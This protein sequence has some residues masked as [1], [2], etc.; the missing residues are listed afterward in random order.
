MPDGLQTDPEDLTRSNDEIVKEIEVENEKDYLKELK[1]KNKGFL[2]E[3]DMLERERIA[4]WICDRHEEALPKHKELCDKLDKYDEVYRMVPHIPEG[5][6]GDD[7]TYVSPLSTVTTEVIHANVMNVIHSPKEVLRVLPTEEGDVKKVNKVSVF[8]NWSMDNE[9]DLFRCTDRLF[10]SSAKNGECP[11][12]MTCD[13]QYGTEIIREIL[14]NPANPTEPL[15]DPNTKEVLYQEVEKTKLLY[16]GPKF[17]VFSR[18]DYIQ[19]P[20]AMMGKTPHYEMKVVRLTYDMFYRESLQGKMYPAAIDEIVDW[21]GQT[22]M[23]NKIADYDG[24]TSIVKYEKEFI[25]FYGR[26]RINVLKEG[27]EN[28]LED[29]D[30][31]E[32]EFIALVDVENEVLCQLRK[33]KFPLKERP[34]DIDY[35]MPDDEGRRCALGVL[36]LMDGPQ[37]AYDALFNQFLR[38]TVNSNEPIAFFSPFGNQKNEPKKIKHGYMYPTSDPNGVQI[39]QLPAPNASLKLL[40]DTVSYWA[41]LLFGISEYSAGLESTIDPSASGKK[42]EAVV[43]QGSVRLNMIIK[44]KN[45]TLKKIFRK[46]FLLYK[47]NMPPNK[48]MRIAGNDKDNPWEFQ[49]VTYQDFD[50]KSIPDFE[51]TGNILNVNKTLEVSKRL[52][53]YNV[54]IGNPLFSPQTAQGLQAIHSLTKWLVDG[55]DD[56]TGLSRIVPQAAG[57]NVQTPEEENARF[58]QGDTGTPTEGEDHVYHIKIHNIRSEEHT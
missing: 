34:I 36:E 47:E 19:P 50:L 28:E 56:N 31:L 55:L 38:G 42:V 44:R 9:L 53:V 14:Y 35:F 51:L 29:Y 49:N 39:F 16:N 10:H 58:M 13:K 21:Q 24:D 1:V 26:I 25:E 33:N 4:R 40:M 3:L 18:R 8:G 6:D 7:S 52:A 15:F 27:K 46:W 48:F 17:E 20:N 32:D 2:V 30:E 45:E 12:I 41:Q 11:W 54:L 5:S 43:A 22:T 23:S 57:D 37:T